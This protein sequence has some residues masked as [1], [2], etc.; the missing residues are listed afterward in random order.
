MSRFNRLYQLAFLLGVF[1]SC[2]L[3][4]YVP[5]GDYL[6]SKNSIE[7]TKDSLSI[8]KHHLDVEELSS[9]IKQ[10]PN[11]RILLGFRFHLRLYNAS[12]QKRIE[13]RIPLKQAKADK[14][15]KRIELRNE[16]KTAKN[17]TYKPMMLES[18]RLTFGEKLRSAGEQPV[19]V[20]QNKVEKSSKQLSI[21]LIKK[22]FF[23]NIVSDSISIRKNNKQAD[24]HY[25]IKTGNPYTYKSIT[26][27][28]S[29]TLL[30]KYLDSLKPNSLLK[31]G[32]N[33]DT[34][35]LDKERKRITDYLLNKGYHYFN[36]EF[37][38][39]RADTSVGDAKVDLVMG[40]QNYKYKAAFSDTVLERKHS[41]YR[42]SG[43]HFRLK[44]GYIVDKT[45][46]IQ[47]SYKG[48]TI[49]YNSKLICKPELL[50]KQLSFKHGDYYSKQHTEA[51]Y[52]KLANLGLFDKVSIKFD[53]SNA[54]NGLN[55]FIDLVE[56]KSQTFM[57]STDG[58]H[59][60]GLLGIE[61]S[62]NYS[63][64]NIFNGAEHFSL[65]LMGGV[66]SQLLYTESN[67]SLSSLNAILFNTVEF[68]PNLSLTL[69]KYLFINKLKF[70]KDHSSGRT[71]FTAS[72]NY[73]KRPDFTR[74]MQELSFGW[75][76]HEKKAISWH[77]NP[78]I[79]SAIDI[80]KKP[81]FEQQI[82]ELNDQ[83]IAASFQDHIIAGGLYSF[84]YNGQNDKKVK[85][86]FYL[87]ATLET[88]GG[89]LYRTHKLLKRP[90]DNTSPNSYNLLGIRYAHF[91]KIATDLRY[92]I[93][94]GL[95]SKLVYR[96]A[97]GIGVPRENLQEALPFEKSFF[98]GGANG[99]RAWRARSLGPGAYY[100]QQNR[101]DKIGDIQLEGNMELRFPVI[102]WVEGAFFLDAG[103]VWLINEDPLRPGGKFSSNFINDLAVGSGLGVRMDLEFFIIRMDLGIPIRNPSI[104]MNDF[105]EEFRPWIF[106][107]YNSAVNA[108]NRFYKLQFNLGIG[109]PF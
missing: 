104:Q 66:E 105:S 37:V 106:Q 74:S 89:L 3:T 22:G 12:N 28:I 61:G 70:L 15:N 41:R 109:Y 99:M 97:G 88:A 53:S 32:S 23:N 39:F 75:H 65:S 31:V 36:K 48:A 46:T 63:H 24:V 21:Y 82:Q 50:H 33:F 14:K 96:L 17:P 16:R 101:F 91:Q 29:D 27:S 10:Q 58:T 47:I 20:D 9:I 93:P 62:L 87:K 107:S 5:D 76:I 8:K 68:G 94:L 13:K 35:I 56:A 49:S 79:I 45:D 38:F 64:R 2:S 4:K 55:V 100:D 30:V 59:N 54:N 19:V 67:D 83:F 81:E 90:Y 42:I 77:I 40:I 60:E 84:E 73:Q 43:I 85:N 72:L 7:F 44:P 1:T 78:L 98:S 51:T 11:R 102:S 18:R 86:V 71:E 69:P 34:D 26:Y 92:Y 108:D 95:K 25:L 57:L 103:N 80:R 6:L 52:R